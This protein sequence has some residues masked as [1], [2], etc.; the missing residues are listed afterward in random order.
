[1]A[2]FVYVDSA[3]GWITRI[4][5]A[6][7]TT[8]GGVFTGGVYDTDPGFTAATGGTVTESGNFKIHTFTGDGCFVVSKIGNAAGGG[9]TAAYLVAAGG[10]GGAAEENRRCEGQVRRGGGGAAWEAGGQGAGGA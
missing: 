3:K 1:M 10:G 6:A 5:Q 7:G 8:P 2:E 9:N 4:L